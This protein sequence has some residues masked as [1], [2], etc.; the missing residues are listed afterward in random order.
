VG[1]NLGLQ[2]AGESGEDERYVGAA[3]RASE[4]LGISAV[5]LIKLLHE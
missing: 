2:A 1:G 5:N 4:P 3:L